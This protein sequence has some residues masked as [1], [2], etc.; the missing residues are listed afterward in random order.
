MY[1]IA[2][3]SAASLEK[4]KMGSQKLCACDRTSNSLMSTNI[5]LVDTVQQPLATIVKDISEITHDGLWLNPFRGIPR[6]RGLSRFDVVYLDEK[7]RV[8]QYIE[9]YAEVE[10]APIGKDAASALVLPAHSL[11]LSR[12]QQGD[13][14]RICGGSEAL[15][16]FDDESLHV[17]DGGALK[18]RTRYQLLRPQ[19][20]RL[21]QEGEAERALRVEGEEKPSLKIRFLRWLF[22]APGDR[23]RGERMPAPDLIAY[24]WTGGAPQ[25]YQI[26][27]VSQSGL[28]MLT[29]ER[30]LPGT[31]IVMTL[32]KGDRSDATSEDIHQV[33]SEVIRWGLDGVGCAFVES[34]F[35]D[36]NS[37]E[38]VENQKFDR[39]AFEHFLCRVQRPASDVEPSNVP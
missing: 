33:E 14:F 5:N 9:N 7:C 11:A 28:Y 32:Q 38:V 31:R 1:G 36:L 37:G 6:G 15:A 3:R 25:A 20:K 35:V 19:T 24:Y 29:E 39:E 17:D 12:I 18:C 16:G 8:L 30:W 2:L 23:R 13:Q 10:F 26:G 34:G 21:A 22:P 4:R 27:N